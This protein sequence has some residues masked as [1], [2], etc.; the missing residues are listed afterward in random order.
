MILNE[1]RPAVSPIDPGALSTGL[2]RAIANMRSAQHADGYWWAELEANA[3]MAAEHL[4]LEQFLGIGDSER[5]GK[6]A[7]YLLGLQQPD[8][9]WPIFYGGPG[10]ISIT[11][12]AYFALKLAGIDPASA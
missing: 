3:T 2:D 8:G 6:T 5:C 10:D 4:L 12:E 9:S 7:R 11:T 1:P